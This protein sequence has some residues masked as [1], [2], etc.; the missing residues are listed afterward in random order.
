MNFLSHISTIE[1]LKSNYFSNELQEYKYLFE[2][3][4]SKPKIELEKVKN[5]KIINETA[6][7]FLDMCF[8]NLEI[9]LK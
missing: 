2:N 8:C 1:L 5:E 3:L 9:Y 7:I 6:N 4:N